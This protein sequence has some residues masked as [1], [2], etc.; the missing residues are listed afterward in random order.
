MAGEAGLCNLI[1]NDYI[2]KKKEKIYLR[3]FSSNLLAAG[4]GEQ[5]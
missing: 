5:M 2:C 3:Q 1:S 4:L